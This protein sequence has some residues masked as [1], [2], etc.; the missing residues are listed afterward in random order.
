[1]KKSTIV[2]SSKRV[3]MGLIRL[4]VRTLD[5]A[6]PALA[7]WWAFRIWATPPHP[8]RVPPSPAPPGD[9]STVIMPSGQEVVV[10]SWGNEG[11][12]I[13]YLVHG[14]GGW[15]QQLAGMVEP[16]LAAG[17][18]VV[19]LDTPGHGDSSSGSLGGRRTHLQEA[20][21]AVAAVV[22]AIGPPYAMVGHSGGASAIAIAIHDGLPV[23][24]LVFIAP[25]ADLMPH[26]DRY[27]D[28][29]GLSGRTRLRLRQRFEQAAGRDLAIF[30]LPGWVGETAPGELPPLLVIHDR[31]DRAVPYA[32]GEAIAAAWPGA[33]LRHTDG[34]GHRRILAD[35]EVTALAAAFVTSG[36][37]GGSTARS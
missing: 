8:R 25:M 5:R 13:T 19:T 7:V 20:A 36:S 18:R 14:W 16:L 3:R 29:L 12:P 31:A 27:V 11:D 28:L 23:E 34:L 15:R 1:M 17:Q 4:G 2:R 30:D 6:A 9:R 35:P 26:A 32:D 10:E 24:R 33:V 21:E 22:K 37:T